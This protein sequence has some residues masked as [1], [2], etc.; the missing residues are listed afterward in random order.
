M[1]GFHIER[2]INFCDA[3]TREIF[4]LFAASFHRTGCFMQ[5]K[6]LLRVRSASNIHGSKKTA[7]RAQMLR[8]ALQA[9]DDAEFTYINAVGSG[10]AAIFSAQNPVAFS[11]LSQINCC[12]AEAS[13]VN[14]AY[15]I[16]K[17]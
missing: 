4:A 3:N 2:I 11:Y 9:S 14:R 15:V 5:A 1:L 12:R 6:S 8:A 16:Y 10:H 17:L 13:E 7:Q